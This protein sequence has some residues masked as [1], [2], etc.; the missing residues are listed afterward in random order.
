MQYMGPSR[1]NGRREMFLYTS[2]MGRRKTRNQRKTCKD[3]MEEM[4]TKVARKSIQKEVLERLKKR[5][6]IHRSRKIR[7][8]FY[9]LSKFSHGKNMGKWDLEGP[10]RLVGGLFF[11]SNCGGLPSQYNVCVCCMYYPVS[12]IR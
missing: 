10:D 11:L 8:K 7:P 12:L 4:E 1:K 9:C 6:K 5:S 2:R 3:G